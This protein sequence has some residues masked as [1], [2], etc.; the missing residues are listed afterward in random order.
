LALI[1]IKKRFKLNLIIVGAGDAIIVKEQLAKAKIP[2]II[3]AMSNLPSSFDTLHVSL[4]NAAELTAAG[5]KVILSVD[6]VHNLYQLRFSAGNAVANGLSKTEALASITA[7]VA[8][9]FGLDTGSIAIGKKA[10]LVL[11]SSDPFEL[12]SHVD[13]LWITGQE[14]STKSRQDALRDRYTTQSDMPKAYVK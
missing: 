10:D 12:S 13:K 5:I 3:N 1:K 14:Y 7:N 9:V 11:W 4:D 8:D 2:L 6:D